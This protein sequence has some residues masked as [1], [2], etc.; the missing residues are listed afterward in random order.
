MAENSEVVVVN[1][2]DYIYRSRERDRPEI[3]D[4]DMTAHPRHAQAAAVRAAVSLDRGRRGRA[5]LSRQCGHG[6][7]PEMKCSRSRIISCSLSWPPPIG[8]RRR[9]AAPSSKRLEARL[10]F[11]AGHLTAADLDDAVRLRA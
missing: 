6:A 5:R 3:L 10:R 4:A 2:T 9:S 1:T 8:C 7:A 11:R